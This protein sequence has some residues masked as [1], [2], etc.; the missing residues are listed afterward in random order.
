MARH[1]IHSLAGTDGRGLQPTCTRWEGASLLQWR[2]NGKKGRLQKLPN[3]NTHKNSITL[4]SINGL[5]EESEVYENN[6]SLGLVMEV[7]GE[8]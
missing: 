5:T 2:E 4:S 3:S 7:G 8:G 1:S 6:E